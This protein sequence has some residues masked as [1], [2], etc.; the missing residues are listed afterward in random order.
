MQEEREREK[1][2]FPLPPASLQILK[3][4]YSSYSSYSYSYHHHPPPPLPLLL[5]LIT[6]CLLAQEE[7]SLLEICLA[8]QIFLNKKILV[9][10]Q[11]LP[12][13]KHLHCVTKLSYGKHSVAGSAPCGSHIVALPTMPCGSKRL[14]TP[15]ATY[16][17]GDQDIYQIV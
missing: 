17:R 10:Q 16:Y 13:Y 12:E 3:S 8:M 11:L 15:A 2:R 6:Q 7:L 1:E 14:G 9:L 4:H 5:L